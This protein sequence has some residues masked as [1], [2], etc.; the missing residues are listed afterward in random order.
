MTL[1]EYIK[2]RNISIKELLDS[3]YIDGLTISNKSTEKIKSWNNVP[4]YKEYY[5]AESTVTFNVTATKKY[6]AQCYKD[7]AM[8]GGEK[9]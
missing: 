7:N 3:H 4:R 6:P 9:R 2:A 1:R 5:I 8:K